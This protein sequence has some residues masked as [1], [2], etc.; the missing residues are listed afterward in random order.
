MR[1][2]AS[3]DGKDPNSTNAMHGING[4][5]GEGFSTFVSGPSGKSKNCECKL[6]SFGMLVCFQPPECLQSS[7]ACETAI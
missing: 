2:K 1:Q 5:N 7:G 3:D 4:S 6:W